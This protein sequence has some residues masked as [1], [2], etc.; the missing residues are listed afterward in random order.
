MPVIERRD[1]AAMA[2]SAG[3]YGGIRVTQGKITVACDQAG[4]PVDVRLSTIDRV[5]VIANILK[6]RIENTMTESA[7]HE[8]ADLAHDTHGNYQR[9]LVGSCDFKHVAVKRLAAIEK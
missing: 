3:N 7:L 8:I 1:S 6:K 5:N 9:A 4:Y 2:F